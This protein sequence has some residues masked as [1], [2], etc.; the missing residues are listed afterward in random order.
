MELRVLNYFLAVVREKNITNAANF[1][2]I[3]QPALSKQLKQL[4]DE[5]GVIL[6]QRGNRE[7]ELTD[8]GRFLANRAKEILDLVEKTTLNISSEEVV[9]GSVA[10][11]GG[12]TEAMQVVAKAIKKMKRKHP[13]IKIQLY[14][15]NGDYISEMLDNG[16]LDFGLVID[17][18]EKQRYNY[19][20]LNEVNQWGLLVREDNPL[21]K[22]Q[23]LAVDDLRD[24]PLLIADQTLVD[25]RIAEWAGV[26]LQN[27]QVVG[28]YNLL[29]NASLMVKEG[30]ASA[31]CIDGII[32]TSASTLVFIPLEPDLISN[33]NIIWKKDFL[34]SKAASVFLDN[35]KSIIVSS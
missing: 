10:I 22:K 32:N 13:D 15:G 27:F 34:P 28:T 18:V 20:K 16:L 24:I 5:L 26:S 11:G 35:L 31:L 29:Y 6:F 2:H 7:I 17:P 19:F 8:E 25:N 23:S 3:T 4:E 21:A 33:L 14:S 30:L 12:E 9:T 1:L